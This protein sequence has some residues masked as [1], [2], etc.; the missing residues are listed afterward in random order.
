MRKR[1]LHHINT[2]SPKDLLLIKNSSIT[3]KIRYF[4]HYRPYLNKQLFYSYADEIILQRR[5]SDV[6]D[7]LL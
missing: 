5:I 4:E 2:T 1:E 3:A 6:I 7:D